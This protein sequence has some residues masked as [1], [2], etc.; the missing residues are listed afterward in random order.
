MRI[1]LLGCTGQVGSELARTLP[2][3]G[4]L[5]TASRSGDTSHTIDLQNLDKLRSMLDTVSPDI[6][7][8]A[9]AYTAVDKAESEPDLALR[10]NGEVPATIGTWAA[11][12]DA[13]VVHYSTDY[14]YDGTKNGPYLESDKPNPISV[15]G[16]TK[17]AG[18]E[19]LLASGCT[20]LILRV[21]W[22][23]S[24]QGHN[25]LLTMQRLMQERAALGIVDD[26]FGTPTWSR[27]IAEATAMAVE[28]MPTNNKQRQSLNGIYHMTP[29]GQTSW[30][31]F[32]SAIREQSNLRCELSP[33]NTEAY[34]TPAQRPKN[35]C[36]DSTK[37]KDAFGIVL[38]NWNAELVRCLNSQT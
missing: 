22:V 24:L 4:T 6:I 35:S 1:L 15:Y 3:V 37:L 12:H 21:S 31:G 28:R 13:L 30:F 10:L 20:V 2:S 33:I 27:T 9:S 19:S 26:Q 36:M 16:R 18:D 14:V 5:V 32:A 8:N 38:P 34:P 17:L 7:V 29:L 23:Y 11:K 25:F